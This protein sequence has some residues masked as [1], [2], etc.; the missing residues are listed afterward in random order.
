MTSYCDSCE[1]RGTPGE[2][3]AGASQHGWFKRVEA[4]AGL[5]MYLF[6]RPILSQRRSAVSYEQEK[7]IPALGDRTDKGYGDG[8]GM[9]FSMYLDRA[10]D[11]GNRMAEYVLEGRR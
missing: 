3:R 10:G 2:C 7:H 5:H 9:L 6:F 1:Q 8:S 4:H 11:E